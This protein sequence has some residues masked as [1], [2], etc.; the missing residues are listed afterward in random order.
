MVEGSQVVPTVVS[1]VYWRDNF[2]ELHQALPRYVAVVHSRSLVHHEKSDLSF[3]P[4]RGILEFELRPVHQDW[5]KSDSPRYRRRSLGF[6]VELQE[7][8]LTLARHQ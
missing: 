3:Y 4:R 6:P 5:A 2:W 1:D 7:L 8:Q